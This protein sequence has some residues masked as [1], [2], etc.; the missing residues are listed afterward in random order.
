MKESNLKSLQDLVSLCKRRGFIFQGSEIYGGLGGTYDYGP[1]GAELKNTMKQRWWKAMTY[2]E[3]IEGIDAAILMNPTTWKASGHVDGFVDPMVDCKHCKARHRADKINMNAPC[4]QCG[5]SGTFTDIREFNL[6]FKTQVGAVEDEASIVYLRPETAQGIFV[7]FLNV[8]GSMRKKLP[9]GIAQIGKAFRNEITPGNFTFRTREF[10]QM[11]MQYFVVPQTQQ[12]HMDEWKN[13]RM[14]W[15]LSNGLRSE[16][17][18]FTPHDKLAHYADAALDIEYEFP[19]GWDEIEG[20][21]SRTNFDLSQ[22]EKFSGKN[23]HYVDQQNNNEKY[24]PFVVETAVGLDRSILAILCDSYRIENE[25]EGDS[26]RTVMR[27]KPEIAPVKVAIL[28]LMKKPELESVAHPLYQ[29]L[30]KLYKC[31]YDATTSI[32]KRY[33]RQDEIGTPFCIT[34]DFDSLTDHQVTIRHRDTM[35]QERISLDQVENFLK[36]QF[37]F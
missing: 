8:Q 3:D 35:I 25:G 9:F 29:R 36:N 28:P 30:Q 17:L 31:E 24:I 4:P 20:I 19:A 16:K 14:Q 13:T 6:M 11:E 26:E 37:N 21:H 5:K 18:R 10:E 1:L 33:R 23:L 15:H 34:I 32:G 2:R 12:K 22:H 27:F 7:N